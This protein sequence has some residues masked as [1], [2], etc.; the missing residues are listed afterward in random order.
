MHDQCE[1]P[2][3][4]APVVSTEFSCFLPPSTCSRI[5]LLMILQSLGLIAG[6]ASKSSGEMLTRGND[7]KLMNTFS[8]SRLLG[9]SQLVT[10]SFTFEISFC[11]V[12][13]VFAVE[14]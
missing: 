6:L 1:V 13:A 8:A 4:E 3:Q 11:S 2:E 12:S 9:I 14:C 10:H 5:A 7:L